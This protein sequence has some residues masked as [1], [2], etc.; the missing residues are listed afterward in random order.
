MMSVATWWPVTLIH[1]DCLIGKPP[2]LIVLNAFHQ[3]GACANC[4]STATAIDVAKDNQGRLT[5][6]CNV[7]GPKPIAPGH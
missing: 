5:V 4:G 3:T 1:C 6:I 7:T 2:S